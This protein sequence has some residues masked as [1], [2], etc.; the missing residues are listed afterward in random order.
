MA[1]YSLRVSTSPSSDLRFATGH[2]AANFFKGISLEPWNTILGNFLSVFQGE[3][4]EHSAKAMGLGT[5]RVHANLVDD[6][7]KVGL[8]PLDHG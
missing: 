4:T 6:L 1:E 8:P 3:R 2:G 7:T 5:P